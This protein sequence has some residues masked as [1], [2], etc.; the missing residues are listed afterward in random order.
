MTILLENPPQF[1]WQTDLGRLLPALRPQVE[2]LSWII[3]NL[4]CLHLGE[5]IPMVAGWED[6][7][8]HYYS[9][10]VVPGKTLYE[11]MVGKDIQVVWG[12][13]CGVSGEVPNLSNEEVPYADGNGE[14]WTKPESFQLAASEIEVVCFDSDITLIKFRDEKLGYRFLE[15][16]PDGQILRN[17]LDA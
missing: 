3:S 14:L 15:V 11:A 2:E 17:L 12:V 4:Q 5:N 7:M 6:Q 1:R 13:F 10:A 16:F 8:K 9:Y